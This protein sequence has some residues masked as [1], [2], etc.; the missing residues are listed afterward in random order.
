MFNGER[1]VLFDQTMADNH[2]KARAIPDFINYSFV[3]AGKEKVIE[4]DKINEDEI[5]SVFKQLDKAKPIDIVL[6]MDDSLSKR[7]LIIRQGNLEY[8]LKKLDFEN[9]WEN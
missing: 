2:Y 7:Q 4:F 6:R 3:K 1:E 8:P 5:F 9:M